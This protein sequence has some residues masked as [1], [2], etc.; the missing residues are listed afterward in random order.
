MKSVLWIV[1]F[2]LGVVVGGGIVLVARPVAEAEAPPASDAAALASD[3]DVPV[4]LPGVLVSV[5]NDTGEALKNVE[6][7]YAGG[8]FYTDALSPAGSFSR[9][10]YPTGESALEV[11]F[12]D[13]S[14]GEVCSE[15]DAQLSSGESGSLRLSIQPGGKLQVKGDTTAAK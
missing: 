11:A 14:G 6:V 1:V 15:V 7:H 2:L 10:I 4:P 9:R 12:A 13:Q 3:A 8:S 5:T